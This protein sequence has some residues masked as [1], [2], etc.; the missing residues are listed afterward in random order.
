MATKLVSPDDGVAAVA[1][2]AEAAAAAAEPDTLIMDSPLVVAKVSDV[3]DELLEGILRS[4]H[5]V[6]QSVASCSPGLDSPVGRL[7]SLNMVKR[8]FRHSSLNLELIKQYT[9]MLVDE[10]TTRR[11]WLTLKF[12]SHKHKAQYYL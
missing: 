4:Q 10:L 6:V 11:K 2:A 12:A 8:I 9:R 7:Q 3:L 5:R 1:A